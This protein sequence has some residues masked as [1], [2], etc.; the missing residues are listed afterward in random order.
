VTG[1]TAAAR[2]RR[3]RASRLVA[4][5]A[6]AAA[7]GLGAGCSSGEVGTISLGLVAA[8]G[9]SLDAVA[10]LRVTVTSPRQELEI[11]RT[12]AGFSL[13]LD[14]EAD[15][16]A[17]A[18]LVDALDAG[19]ARVATGSSPPF[20]LAA[21][22]ARVVVYLAP[23]LSVA[24]APVELMPAR[25]GAA[26]APLSYGA[27]LAGGAAA[28]GA[29]SDALQI[30]NAYDHSLATGLPL[31]QPRRGATIAT[32][33]TNGV[34]LFGGSGPSGAATGSL[35]LFQ[36][37]VAPAGR[38]VQLAESPQL[39]RSDRPAIARGGD[40]FLIGGAPPAEL[41]GG[42]VAEAADVPPLASGAAVTAGAAGEVIAIAVDESSGALLRLRG[43]GAP[44]PLGVQRVG[45]LA[46]AL[47]G[48]R[49]AVLG[50]TAAATA[51]D[52]I[53]VDAAAGGVT[54]VADALREV[55]RGLA[56]AATPRFLVVAGAR[57]GDTA[58][59]ILD[60]GTLAARGLATV[61]DAI[62]SAV[63]LPND[64]VLLAGAAL[65]LFTPPPPE[66]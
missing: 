9:T 29:P 57:A 30:Y 14:L 47:P 65:W 10:R 5:A 21:I 6:A 56:A 15:G 64:Q 33:P 23:A 38:Y 53:V 20:R 39:A 63:A 54:V 58:I 32:T 31:P 18:I 7:A 27:V 41:R 28:G 61:P 26:V 19:G 40:R 45:G 66:E 43:D 51:R 12:A 50:G 4:A 1:A 8:P 11:E 60:A 2:A 17:A 24:R 52:V 16:R 22:T 35:W 44:E 13:T 48:G 49:V 62:T 59:E 37:D 34:Y 36:S 55:Y 25:A 42:R 3:A 46:T